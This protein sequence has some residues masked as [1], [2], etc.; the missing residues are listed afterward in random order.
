VLKQIKQLVREPKNSFGFDSYLKTIG[1]NDYFTRADLLIKK[2]LKKKKVKYPNYVKDLDTYKDLSDSESKPKDSKVT[3]DND[4]S[5]SDDQKIGLTKN[6]LRNS[7][8]KRERLASTSN[9]TIRA[10]YAED[11]K[12]YYGLTNADPSMND[13]IDL[14][15]N[16]N[17]QNQRQR[18]S[19]GATKNFT[20]QG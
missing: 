4:V 5:S 3:S 19:Y 9:P 11:S 10:G 20:M 2:W 17:G 7:P 18:K 6:N 13:A 12:G 16:A 8:Q 15:H 1:F 14:L